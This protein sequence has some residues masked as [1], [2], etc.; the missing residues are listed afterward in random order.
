VHTCSTFLDSC[1]LATPLNVE[2]EKNANFWVLPPKGDTIN[3]SRR[4][5]A[6]KHIPWVC[7]S[8]PSLVGIGKRVLVQEPP[9]SKFAQT[10]GFWPPEADTMNTFRWYLACKCRSWVC[11][12]TPNLTIVGFGTGTP[13]IK[14]CPK[15][16]FLATGSRHSEHIHMKFD[17]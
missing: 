11:H 12:S 4:I 13:I 14:S 6:S 7:Y 16:W 10:C 17:V 2:V 15:L 8:T 3:R 5:L 1:Q 9:K